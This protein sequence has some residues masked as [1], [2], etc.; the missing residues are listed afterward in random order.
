MNVPRQ[1]I[2]RVS[3]KFFRRRKLIAESG[4]HVVEIIFFTVLDMDPN[5]FQ[6]CSRDV[7]QPVVLVVQIIAD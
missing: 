2:S 6:N 5:V 7:V 1:R 3:R 4:E